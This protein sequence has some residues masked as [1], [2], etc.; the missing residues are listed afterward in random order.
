M[1]VALWSG[2]AGCVAIAVA[3]GLAE[4]RR[5]RRDDPDRVGFVPWPAVQL[6][7]LFAAVIVAA[8]AITG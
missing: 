6:A 8:L 1:Q 2:V 5:G 4:R 3:S 7:A